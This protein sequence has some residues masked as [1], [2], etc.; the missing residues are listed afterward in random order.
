MNKALKL[1]PHFTI[2]EMT[3]SSHKEIRNVPYDGA[4]DNLIILCLWLEKLRKAYNDWLDAT[5]ELP[6]GQPHDQP[7]VINSAYRCP[8]LNRV[9]GGQADSNHLTGCACDISAKDGRD[10]I[11]KAELLIEMFDGL[12]ESWDEVIVERKGAGTWW[13][14]FAVRPKNGR[15]PNRRKVSVISA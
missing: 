1:T 10:A 14:H 12:G 4:L 7:I 8:M 11:L 3:V 15:Q 5:S 13:V 2:G 6:N 9:V